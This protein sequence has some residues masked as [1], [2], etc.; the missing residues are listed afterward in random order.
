MYLRAAAVGGAE[1]V[2]LAAGLS[3]ATDFWRSHIIRVRTGTAPAV[4]RELVRSQQAARLT[5]TPLRDLARGLNRSWSN[6]VPQILSEE[7]AKKLIDELIESLFGESA[8]D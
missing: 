7:E 2:A 5:T 6:S 3:N 4:A 8:S 1:H